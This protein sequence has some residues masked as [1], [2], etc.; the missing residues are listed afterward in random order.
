MGERLEEQPKNKPY[1]RPCQNVL[2][3]NQSRPN[4]R[5]ST[6]RPDLEKSK[7]LKLVGKNYTKYDI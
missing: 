1:P 3:K 2:L 7:T 6:S 5:T 4:Q